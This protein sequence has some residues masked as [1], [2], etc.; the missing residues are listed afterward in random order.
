MSKAQMFL[1]EI[2]P[3][4]IQTISQENIL[5]TSEMF[6]DLNEYLAATRGSLFGGLDNDLIKGF[7]DNNGRGVTESIFGNGG[8][9]VIYGMG[10]ADVL[11]GD[12]MVGQQIPDN[13]NPAT[14]LGNDII[15]GDDGDLDNDLFDS[16]IG[17]VGIGDDDD[18]FGGL[19]DDWLFGEAGDDRLFGGPQNGDYLSLRRQRNF[20][21]SDRDHL[22]GGVGDDD[23]IGGYDNDFLVGGVGDD[24]LTGSSRRGNQHGY[25]GIDILW[26]DDEGGNGS[27]GRDRFILGRGGELYYDDRVAVSNGRDNVAVIM[28]FNANRDTILLPELTQLANTRYTELTG[29][30]P[31]GGVYAWYTVSQGV[32]LASVSPNA[33]GSLGRN[34]RG[35]AIY[36]GDNFSAG[37]GSIYNP[38]LI[39]FV[40]NNTTFSLPAEST[41]SVQYV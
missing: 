16:S 30:A 33:V 25:D 6:D 13:F 2:L 38:E 37:S 27:Q 9:D 39:A 26:G 15:F 23:L 17:P 5:D 19:G 28:D 12:L 1:E 36:Y 8:D 32:D 29:Q 4:V 41:S 35:T 31:W 40:A 34:P 11:W 3:S 22:F 18:I 21:V 7:V 10:G 14:D 20:R 24:N